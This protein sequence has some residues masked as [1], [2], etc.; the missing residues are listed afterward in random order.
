MDNGDPMSTATADSGDPLST[1]TGHSG[2]PTS[3]AT[4]DS[5]DLASPATVDSDDP[6][7]LANMGILKDKTQLESH[8]TDGEPNARTSAPQ[9]RPKDM[10]L[11]GKLQDR[12]PLLSLEDAGKHL[13]ALRSLNY[14]K[15]SGI[16]VE[17]IGN[18]VGEYAAGR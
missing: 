15:L 2:D 7:N 14:G 13:N 4:V 11:I 5:G 3:T 1:A 8:I 10:N 17:T 12:Y 16:S 9:L 18:M 6:V